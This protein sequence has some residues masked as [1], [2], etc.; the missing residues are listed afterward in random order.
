ML[1]GAF[2]LFAPA[3]AADTSAK[4]PPLTKKGQLS[5]KRPIFKAP[6]LFVPPPPPTQASFSGLG[7]TFVFM[8]VEPIE[9]MSEK[10]V[11]ELKPKTEVELEKAGKEHSRAR[12][13]LAELNKRSLLFEEL[14]K[15]GVIS[16]RELENCKKELKVAE[17]DNE[18]AAA[19]LK[20]LEAKSKRLELRLKSFEKKPSK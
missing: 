3:P 5:S 14:F 18:E 10:A 15:E 20:E 12:D 6:S 19:K 17:E 4:K 9:L 7:P 1:A 2:S 8:G 13:G 16:R 11:R